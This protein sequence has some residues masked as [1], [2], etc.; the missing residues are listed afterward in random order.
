MRT[1][2]VPSANEIKAADERRIEKFYCDLAVRL[3]WEWLEAY[4]SGLDEFLRQI[5]KSGKISFGKPK[6]DPT[7]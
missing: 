6:E 7:P 5:R 1:E 3:R 4:F 2:N